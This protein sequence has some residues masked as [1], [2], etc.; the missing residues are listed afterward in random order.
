MTMLEM[1]PA[2]AK[3]FS[4]SARLRARFKARGDR[5]KDPRRCRNWFGLILAQAALMALLGPA[6]I[7]SVWV[8]P[9]TTLASLLRFIYLVNRIRDY[10][11]RWN[12]EDRALRSWQGGSQSSD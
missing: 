11:I 1:D 5:K 7:M 8:L 9:Y 6:S 10:D 3:W 2:D 4:R 12:Q